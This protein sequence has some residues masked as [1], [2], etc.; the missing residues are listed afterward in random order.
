MLMALEAVT[1]DALFLQGADA[2]LEHP[3]LLGA[4]RRDELLL[5]PIIPTVIG[6]DLYG[7]IAAFRLT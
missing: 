4:V 2:S 1:V 6:C 7:P 3:V 5:E